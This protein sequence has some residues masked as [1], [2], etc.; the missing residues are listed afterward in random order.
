M[1]TP[2]MAKTLRRFSLMAL[3]TPLFLSTAACSESETMTPTETRGGWVI[4]V[5]TPNRT[6][7]VLQADQL[8][9]KEIKL[10]DPEYSRLEL[11]SVDYTWIFHKNKAIGMSY[12]QRDPGVAYTMALQ[13]DGTLKDLGQFQISS[14]FTNYQVFDDNLFI[15]S[16]AGQVSQ[17]GTRTDGAIFEFWNMTPT[18]ST[19][20]G[21]KTIW[22][23]GITQTG[24]LASFSSMV[25]MGDG[26]FLTAMVKSLPRQG[27]GGSSVG[28]VNSPDSCWI[29][30]MDTA[31][32]VKQIY[33]TDKLSYA[34]GQHRSQLFRQVL[35][36]N[37]GTVYVFSGAINAKTTKPSGVMR[38]AHG[39][40]GFDPAYYW[41][42]QEATGG[43][44]FRRVW[45][46]TDDKFLLEVYNQQGSVT[47]ATPAHQY[48]VID[49][50]DKRL[51]WVSGLPAKESIISGANYGGVPT[52]HQG[53]IYL[54]ITKQGEDASIYK[55]DLA[56]GVATKIA[57]IVGAEEI[58]SIGYVQ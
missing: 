37:D 2:T 9:G 7:F 33:A 57:T 8:E 48:A 15:T 29:V 30:R 25:N 39:G 34:A 1:V 21:T 32:N 42:L 35:K 54:P 47:L 27:G 4:A 45:Y 44:K 51:T 12:L 50:S 3:A 17:D 40:N 6:E 10:N 43:Y 31:L 26:T 46:L 58:T 36:A 38:M 53:A 28:E 49:M 16:I 20:R 56:T 41:N 55:A 22:T 19:L 13:S 14:R 52:F 18:G 23:Q 24:E 11:P 5:R